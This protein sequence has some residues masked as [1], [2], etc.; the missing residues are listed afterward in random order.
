MLDRKQASGDIYR[1]RSGDY[2][3]PVPVDRAA[4]DG[5]RRASRPVDESESRRAQDLREESGRQGEQW[6]VADERRA[7]CAA[8]RPDLAQLVR[9]VSQDDVGLGYDVLSYDDRG[10]K[11]HIE[12][13]ATLGVGNAFEL[14]ANEWRV[15]KRLRSSYWIYFVRQL[16]DDP[17]V[18]Q[19]Q[20]PSTKGK[21][22]LSLHPSVF[23]VT[24]R[25]VQAAPSRR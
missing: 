11:K 25:R 19:I 14:T 17:W 22:E 2:M 9:R 13:K 18:T 10:V 23:T 16:Y 15:A 12:V 6:V 1:N 5:S 8:G 3:L 21:A 7:L 24:L 4:A 20:D